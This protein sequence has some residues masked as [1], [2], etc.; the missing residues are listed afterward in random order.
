MIRLNAL[1]MV[2]YVWSRGAMRNIQF[3]LVL[4]FK[5]LMNVLIVLVLT[6]FR[7]MHNILIVSVKWYRQ[8]VSKFSSWSLNE[9]I[10]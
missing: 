9:R 8:E 5:C 6:Y 3:V 7:I 4:E 2:A 10:S 1:L